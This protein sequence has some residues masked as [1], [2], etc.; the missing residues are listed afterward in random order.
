MLLLGDIAQLVVA[1]ALQARCHRFESDYLHIINK[2]Y[3][4][5]TMKSVYTFLKEYKQLRESATSERA[6]ELGY[7]WVRRNVYMDPKSG[8]RYRGDGLKFEEI[9]SEQ[10]AERKPAQQAPQKTLDKFKQD[11]Q[12]RTPVAPQVQ[13][14]SAFP[15]NPADDGQEA[16]M[17]AVAASQ[18]LWPHYTNARKEYHIN[19]EFQQIQADR[20]AAQAELDAQQAELEAQQQAQVEEPPQ[21]A[22]EE[23]RTV[24]DVATEI[25]SQELDDDEKFNFDRDKI[26]S[27][28]ESKISELGDD[29]SLSNFD[30]IVSEYKSKLGALTNIQ[31]KN[32]DKKFKDLRES[33]EKIDD[34]N[35]RKAFMNA[36]T[37]AYSYTGRINSGAGKNALGKVDYELLQQ[38]RER[39]QRGYGDG[40]AEGIKKFVE[41]TRHLEV[42]DE[43]AE[44][45][46]DALPPK[47]QKGFMGA[48]KISDTY[49][50]HFL[51]R[52]QDGTDIRGRLSGK[53]NGVANG[54]L[55]GILVAKLFLQ[56]GGK[57]GY[58]GSDLDLNSTDLEHVRGFNNKDNGDPTQ[59]MKDQRENLDNFILTASNLNQTKVDKNMMEWYESEVDRLKDFSDEDYQKRDELTDQSNAVNNKAKLVNELFFDGDNLSVN[60]NSEMF[61]LYSKN[62]RDMAKSINKSINQFAKSKNVKLPNVQSRIGYEMIKK[63]GLGGYMKKKSGRGNQAKLDDKIYTAFVST[64]MDQDAE[65]RERLSNLWKEARELGSQ[66]AYDE[67]NDGAAKRTLIDHLKNNGGFAD[68]FLKEKEFRRILGE[69]FENLSEIMEDQEELSEW[70][71]DFIKRHNKNNKFF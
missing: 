34:L 38:N 44:L 49:D 64:L 67:Q 40:S 20:A 27:E 2:V 62:D 13:Q 47:L 52:S 69:S 57:D 68:R 6:A 15:S 30:K 53:T 70:N 12:E 60:A 3:Q 11:A 31:N 21:K 1:L 42:S 4:I 41:S 71:I 10:P 19:R 58:T 18:G 36:V 35:K 5:W 65:G 37:L 66:A 43:E 16:E 7:E 26:M 8:K 23:F 46:F 14:P 63:L 17:R 56:Q 50:G 32:V 48:G 28:Y 24:D 54:R 55:R 39:L 61:D 22:P 45:F 9:P 51:G 25:E 29:K 33:I 59:E